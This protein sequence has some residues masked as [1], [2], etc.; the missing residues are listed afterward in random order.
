MIG[1]KSRR[2][3]RR[4]HDA[5]PEPPKPKDQLPHTTS[6]G[7]SA[8]AREACPVTGIARDLAADYRVGAT[9]MGTGH[10]G[11]VRAC[12]HRRTG[13]SLAVKSIDKSK[14]R[15]DQLQQE[16]DL[17]WELRHPGIM[18]A[19]EVCEDARELHIVTERYTGGELFDRITERTTAEG[20]FS[21]AAAAN[22]VRT[23]LAALA[24]L[25]AR[26]IVHRD[27]KPEN[28][29]FASPRPGAG[30]RL[31]DFGLAR[32]HGPADSPLTDPVGTAYYMA[33]EVLGR[34]YGRECDVWSVGV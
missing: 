15:V 7:A 1:R 4:V 8:A 17:L 16:V 25:H 27:V 19:V 5:G 28:V 10:Y 6:T 23:L 31:I 21:E 22:V 24:H 12:R 26:G 29:L 32:R 2:S 33:P 34:R 14:A 9:V 20:C 13:A 18:R 3:S 30:V 11:V